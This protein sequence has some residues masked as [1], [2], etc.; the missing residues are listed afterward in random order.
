MD[1]PREKN[2]RVARGIVLVLLI[3]L[4][5]LD[6]ATLANAQSDKETWKPIAWAEKLYLPAQ[7]VSYVVFEVDLGLFQARATNRFKLP[8]PGGESIVL[9]GAQIERVGKHGFLWQGKVEGDEYSIATFSIVDE[10]LVGDVVTSRGKM[11]RVD[12]L[13]PRTVVIM[14]LNQSKFPPGGKPEPVL[15]SGRTL[16]TS[17]ASTPP[18]PR[19]SADRIDV[20]VFY[21]EAACAAA[22]NSLTQCTQSGRSAIK[23]KVDQAVG[24]ANQTY[25]NSS[26]NQRLSLV[27]FDSVGSYSE[28]TVLRDLDLL[29]LF[30]DA[31]REFT[32]E[33]TTY[34]DNVH[35]LRDQYAADVVVLVTRPTDRYPSGAAGG[36]ATPMTANAA[37]QEQQAFAIVPLDTLTGVFAFAHELGHVMGADHDAGSPGD[38]P[39]YLYSHGFT[40]TN[41]LTAGI[42]PWRTVMAYNTDACTAAAP[43]PCGCVATAQNTGACGPEQPPCGC[44]L[45]P[46]WSNPYK[47][48]HG[49]AMG[50]TAT[51]NNHEALNKTA[52]TVANYRVSCSRTPNPPSNVSSE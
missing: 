27:H 3:S 21:T 8:L 43:L 47:Y 32:N 2:S 34:M 4:A 5:C 46:Y 20:M 29:R 39:P 12:H 16:Q 44:A 23:A 11:Y 50:T 28:A 35:P 38:T 45:L 19:D 31:E 30:G 25:M 49:D 1:T 41:P 24:E 42:A 9:Q 17:V 26:V 37:S 6:A 52:D 36:L 22:S 33:T 10:A 18:C 48:H 13:A 14:E 40:K 51:A 7:A 15:K